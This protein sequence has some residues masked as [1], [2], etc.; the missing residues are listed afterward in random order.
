MVPVI[1]G[2]SGS[3]AEFPA[4]CRQLADRLGISDLV[5]FRPPVGQRELAD[6]YRAATVLAMPSHSESF[7]LAALEAQ[8]C[9]T[10]VLA[11]EVGGLTV[12]VRDGVTGRLVRGHDPA[13]YAGV[14]AELGDRPGLADRLGMAATRHAERFG[15]ESCAAATARVYAKALRTRR[16]EQLLAAATV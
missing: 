1:G 9:G 3:G 7:G 2:L 14:L 6:W 15:W 16:A 13:D 11:A 12:A 5:R 10:P 8:A 4:R